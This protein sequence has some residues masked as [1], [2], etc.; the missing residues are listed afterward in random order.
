MMSVKPREEAHERD[1][2]VSEGC[3]VVEVGTMVE[4]VSFWV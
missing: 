3:M 2:G 1:V 4:G